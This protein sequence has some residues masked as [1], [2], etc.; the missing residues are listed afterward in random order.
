MKL[1]RFLTIL[2]SLTTAAWAS[3]KNCGCACCKGKEVCCCH[4]EKT[5]A[6]PGHPLRG[7]VTRVL[8]D[9]RLVMI[10][11]EEIPGFMKAMTMAFS[12]PD[13]VY[14]LLQ[15]GVAL[16]ARMH[17]TDRGWKLDQ[18]KLLDGKAGTQP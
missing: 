15:P 12:V 3:E 18:V 8:E 2:L 5:A 17:R 13:E 16:T 1:I 7:V 10:K 9:R 14:P 6:E 4:E 11:H